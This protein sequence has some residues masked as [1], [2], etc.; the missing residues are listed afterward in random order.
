MKL[1]HR[2]SYHIGPSVCLAALL[3]C[4]SVAAQ[5][6]LDRTKVPPPGKPPVLRVPAWTKAKLAN[7]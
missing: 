2:R 5:Q 4:V 1:F 3:A 6:T 7:G